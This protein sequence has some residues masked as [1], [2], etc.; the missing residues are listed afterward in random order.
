MRLHKG[1][2]VCV[3]FLDHI[4]GGSAPIPFAVYGRLAHVGKKSLSVDSWCHVDPKTP[5]DTNV[6]RVT[7]VR[8][9]ITK[10]VRL[11]PEKE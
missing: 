2:I 8:S 6:D 7:I 5:F 10:I 9:T 3:E 1:H 11:V 4:K